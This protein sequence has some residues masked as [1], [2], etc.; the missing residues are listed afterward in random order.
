MSWQLSCGSLVGAV[1]GVLCTTA[2]A[3]PQA[4]RRTPLVEEQTSTANGGPTTQNLIVGGWTQFTPSPDTR[5]VYVSPSQGSDANSG[6][7]EG[8]PKRTIGAALPLMRHGYPDWLLVRKG[9]VVHTMDVPNSGFQWLTSGRSAAEPTLFGSYGPAGAPRPRILTAGKPAFRITGGGGAP[10][11]IQHVA[12]VGLD[13]ACGRHDAQVFNPTGIRLQMPIV[14]LLI[15]DCKISR[16]ANGIVAQMTGGY[17][18][19]IRI[20]RSVIHD[21][22][23]GDGSHA[24]GIYADEVDGLLIEESVIDHGGWSEWVRDADPADIFKHGIYIQGDARNVTVRGNVISN[25]SSH[26]LQMRYGGVVENNVFVRNAIGLLMAGDGAVRR[27]VFLD[28]RDISPTLP[29]RQALHVQNIPNGVTITNNVFGHSQPSTSSKAVVLQP[30]DLGNGTW[31]GMRNVELER[32]VVWS[33]GGE[34]LD[35]QNFASRGAPFSNVSVRFNDFQNLVDGQELIQHQSNDTVGPL[36][37]AYNRFFGSLVPTNAWARV[38][39]STM[40]IGSY[41]SLVGDPTSSAHAVDY[42]DPW[43]TVE[44]YQA[45][46]G[47]EPTLV[48]F[49]QECKRQSKDNWRPEYTAAAFNA[50][51]R[52]GF[53]LAP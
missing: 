52:A 43:R 15:E 5:I 26:G 33:W 24:Q 13:F 6:L 22:Y 14:D 32:N 21:T 11:L 51:V 36:D 16:F 37:M 41:L 45:A 44:T 4:V 39:G 49:I 20:R 48:D 8:Q 35:I 46:L 27:N 29:R 10:S 30:L 34:T 28:G 19:D 3:E 38:A 50:Y 25:G 9:D 2:A 40:S 1:L 23:A 47:G 12:I 7:S 18:Y 53:G 17:L 31:L 42:P